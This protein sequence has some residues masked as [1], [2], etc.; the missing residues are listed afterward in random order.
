MKK[1]VYIEYSNVHDDY[2]VTKTQNV[3]SPLPSEVISKDELARLVQKA[4]TDVII[5]RKKKK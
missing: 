4:D 3:M 5:T 1:K 2:K